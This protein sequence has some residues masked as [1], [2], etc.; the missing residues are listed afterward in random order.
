V[1]RNSRTGGQAQTTRVERV[2]EAYL[3]AL[4]AGSERACRFLTADLLSRIARANENTI[5]SSDEH[6]L[7][8]EAHAR[9]LADGGQLMLE[10]D[11][12]SA[13]EV[14]SRRAAVST[15][16]RL[17]DAEPREDPIDGTTGQ[18]EAAVGATYHLVRR[19]GRWLIDRIAEGSFEAPSDPDRGSLADEAGGDLVLLRGCADETNYCAPL[20]E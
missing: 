1:L 15:L 12:A 4:A 6:R 13:T 5:G 7:V 14:S 9:D 17:R 2:V 3:Q 11:F 8:C 19:R 18:R 20:I 16:V 10:V